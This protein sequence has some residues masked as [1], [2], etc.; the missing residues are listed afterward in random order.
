MTAGRGLGVGDDEHGGGALQDAAEAALEGLGIQGRKALVEDY[1][2]SLLKQGS[3]HVEPAALAMG[4][5]PAG[6]ADHLQQPRRHAAEEVVEAELAADA[7]G[8]LDIRGLRRPAPAHQQ[9]EGE[10]FGEHVIFVELGRG[11]HPSPP[12]LCPQGLS[13]EPPEE[14]ESGLGHAQAA[15]KGG[16]R[17]FAATRGA[18]EQEPVASGRALP[19]LRP[20]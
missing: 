1:Q 18:F 2:L 15:E 9:V 14:Q 16:Q 13:V 7:F 11:H 12:S 6:F 10:G 20:R 4:Q 19:P 8:R 5:L 3:G 17:G